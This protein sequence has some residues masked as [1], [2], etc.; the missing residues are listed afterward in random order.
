MASF[1]PPPRGEGDPPR[2]NQ[3]I[4]NMIVTYN[5]PTNVLI[6]WHYPLSRPSVR[7]NE[8]NDYIRQLGYRYETLP[9]I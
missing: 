8:V 1:K 4:D 7:F 9:D 6:G 5:R 3:R 2:D